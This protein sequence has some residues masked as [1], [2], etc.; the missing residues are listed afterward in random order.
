MSLGDDWEQSVNPPDDVPAP[1]GDGEAFGAHAD[2]LVPRTGR[3]VVTGHAR[4]RWEDCGFCLVGGALFGASDVPR[5]LDEPVA[6]LQVTP[7]HVDES[8][9][10]EQARE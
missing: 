8:L 4:V 9:Q 2:G 10:R 3:E 5:L 1:V 7:T 6:F